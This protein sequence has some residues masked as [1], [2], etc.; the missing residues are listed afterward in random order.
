[1]AGFIT[2]LVSKRRIAAG[3]AALALLA[4]ASVTV[5]FFSGDGGSV[6]AQ[7]SDT[8]KRF[9]DRSPGERGETDLIK[10][11]VKR[12][13]GGARALSPQ[14]D[15]PQ[16]RALGK[17]FDTPPEDAVEQLSDNPLG[18]L[19]LNDPD[20]SLVPLG[21]VGT[22]GGT[23][24]GPGF[25]GGIATVVPPIAVDPGGPPPIDPPPAVRG[26]VP[27]PGT[28]ALMILGFAFC[29]AALRRRGG[30]MQGRP[31]NA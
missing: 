19:A 9:V 17:I 5:P 23:P 24:I 26:G 11:K 31:G 15:G 14:R 20:P 1:M 27:E 29:G 30:L 3:T 2:Y 22:F 4:T 12:D 21:D 18:P 10:S 6:L 8:L 25:P 28:W 13:F 16:E 7:A